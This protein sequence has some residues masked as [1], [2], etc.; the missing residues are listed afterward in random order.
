MAIY[1][2]FEQSKQ[3]DKMCLEQ[4]L[5]STPSH[6]GLFTSFVTRISFIFLLAADLIWLLYTI[7]QLLVLGVLYG[8]LIGKSA[9]LNCAFSR[10]YLSLRRA[11]ACGV[12]LLIGIFC[13]AFGMMIACT[14]FLMY[15][16]SGVEEVIPKPLQ[17]QFREFFQ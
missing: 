2:L 13:P 14:Y 3:E 10:A 7:G 8:A 6:H 5:E 1:Q 15:D 17:A 11:L 16:R 12:S 4:Q 9:R